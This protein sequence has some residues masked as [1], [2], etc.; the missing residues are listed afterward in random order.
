M[1]MGGDEDM[2]AETTVPEPA[3][4]PQQTAQSEPSGT[5]DAWT[6]EDYGRWG[7]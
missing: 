7:G 5:A 6:P 1:P 3:P 2:T 4:Q